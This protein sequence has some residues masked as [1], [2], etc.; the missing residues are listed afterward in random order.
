MAV[1]VA[2]ELQAFGVSQVER[3]MR[4]GLFQEQIRGHSGNLAAGSKNQD[5]GQVNLLGNN[6]LYGRP[7]RCSCDAAPCRPNDSLSATHSLL[8]MCRV[9]MLLDSNLGYCGVDVVEIAVNRDLM[10]LEAAENSP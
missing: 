5:V 8:Q 6:R 4:V 9:P 3:Q 7:A 2:G 10:G 1:R